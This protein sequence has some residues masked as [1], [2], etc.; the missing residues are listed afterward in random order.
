MRNR[1]IGTISRLK[2]DWRCDSSHR[3]P[4]SPEFKLQSYSLPKRDEKEFWR[5]D[6]QQ[7]E[8]T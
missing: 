1:V 2:R 3:G 7:Y 5:L 4:Q 6:A 8:Y